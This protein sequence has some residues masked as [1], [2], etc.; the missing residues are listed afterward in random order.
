MFGY[1]D[2]SRIANHSEQKHVHRFSNI[3]AN[4]ALWVTT[5]ALPSIKA[6]YAQT[7]NREDKFNDHWHMRHL[8]TAVQIVPAAT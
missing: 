4:L 1:D 5:E 3:K 2:A 8:P 7:T 6:G